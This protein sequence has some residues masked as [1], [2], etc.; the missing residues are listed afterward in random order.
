MTKI[1][2]LVVVVLQ[3]IVGKQP[4]ST[5]TGGQQKKPPVRTFVKWDGRLC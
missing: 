2:S 4:N 5:L 1:H 3:E